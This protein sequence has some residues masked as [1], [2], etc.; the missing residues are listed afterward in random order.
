MQKFAFASLDLLGL[1]VFD[2]R[3][4]GCDVLRLMSAYCRERGRL[5]ALGTGSSP[6]SGEGHGDSAIGCTIEE[7]RTLL[8]AAD[9]YMQV[10]ASVAHDFIDV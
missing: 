5:G 9:E 4:Y 10:V 2:R 7:Q 3:A 8:R 6:H 1:P